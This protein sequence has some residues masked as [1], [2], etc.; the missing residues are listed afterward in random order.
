M[1]L[2]TGPL[3]FNVASLVH[4]SVFVATSTWTLQ[5]CAVTQRMRLSLRDG[6]GETTIFSLDVPEELEE[7]TVAVDTHL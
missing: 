1:D 7:V 6:V 4:Q 5:L 2:R 3:W